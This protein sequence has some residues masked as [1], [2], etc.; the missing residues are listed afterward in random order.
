MKIGRLKLT[1]SN[2]RAC[3]IAVALTLRLSAQTPLTWEQVKARFIAANPTLMAGR[4][5]VDETKAQEITAFLRP[6]PDVSLSVDGTQL[7][8][9]RGV[10]TPFSGTQFTPGISYLHE[11][12]HKRELR[13]E[14]AQQAT[15][16]AALQ[17]ADEERTLLFN[18]RSAFVQTLQAK[19]LL[20]LAK[21]ELDY[22]EKQ[23]GITQDRYRAGDIAQMDMQRIHLQRVQFE[24]DYQTAQVNLRTAKITLL[25]LLDQRTPVDQFDTDGNFEFSP[26]VDTL[27][28]FRDMAL[29]ERPDLRSALAAVEKAETDHRLAIANGSTDP[30]WSVWVTHNPS[31]NNPFDANTIGASV[32]IPLRLFDRNQG[33]KAR[34]E[35]DIRHAQRLKDATQAQVFSDVDSAYFTLMSAVNLLTPYRSTYLTEASDV[36]EKIAFSYQRGGSALLDYLQAQ[37]DYRSVQQAYVN[38][39]ASYLMAA[40]QLNMAVGREV[41]Q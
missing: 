30:T 3:A 27:E 7:T 13:L 32:S 11:R 15:G 21:E 41:I 36:R 33:E 26:T 17:Q 25:E 34:T 39:I 29:A 9:S 35:I 40:A 22:F 8:P 5:N 38:L 14:T 12:Q 10:Y 2:K 1:L 23:Y 31:F 24:S 28:H 37:Q 20:A 16:I 19:H 6:N 4:I 18:L